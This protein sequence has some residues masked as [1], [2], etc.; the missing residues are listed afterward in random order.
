LALKDGYLIVG[1]TRSNDGDVT[2]NH[3]GDSGTSDVWVFK[4]DLNGNLVWQKCYG[5]SDDES[6]LAAVVEYDQYG[7]DEYYVITGWTKSD[8]F[9]VS[10]NHYPGNKDIWTFAI[11]AT[12]NHE[13]LWQRCYGGSGDDIAQYI[14]ESNDGKNW[15]IAG[16]TQSHDGDLQ[17]KKDTLDED[18][19]I[20]SIPR[21]GDVHP[22]DPV[23]N[24]VFGGSRGDAMLA[25][26]AAPASEKGYIATGFTE[27]DDGD[28]SRHYGLAGSRDIWVLKITDDGTLEW[29][30]NFGGSRDDVG[31]AIRVW[32]SRN[33]YYI[34]GYTASND[35]DAVGINH[36]G[37]S[38]SADIFLVKLDYAGNL[39][40]SHCYGGSDDDFGVRFGDRFTEDHAYV[41]GDTYSDDG[42]VAG[43]NHGGSDI[44]VFQLL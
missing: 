1:D 23:F 37:N 11:N 5:G 4:I 18:A 39:L 38:G 21:T 19:W 22:V 14:E 10:G 28:V 35:Y 24:R 40:S 34:L 16:S 2:G 9:D 41:I 33:N 25:I 44:V 36:G 12:G 31:A 27:S 43:M 3:G 42:D 13:I 6:G 32:P 30:K 17:S 29:E 20:F 8:D 15:I 26:Q 7:R